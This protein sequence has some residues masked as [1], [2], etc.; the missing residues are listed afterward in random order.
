[1]EI[2]KFFE[3]EGFAN[4]EWEFFFRGKNYEAFLIY[5]K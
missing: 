3:I 5:R 4:G 1:L 2:N